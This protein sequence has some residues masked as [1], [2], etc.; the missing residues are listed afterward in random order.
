MSLNI[1]ML[2]F[3]SFTIFPSNSAF[4]GFVGYLFF[5]LEDG[6]GGGLGSEGGVVESGV[7]GAVEDAGTA[8]VVF[9]DVGCG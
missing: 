6:F 4:G 5:E 2:E 8:G 3:V 9:L 7:L 1:V